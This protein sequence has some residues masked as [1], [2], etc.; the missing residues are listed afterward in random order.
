M[1]DHARSYPIATLEE[2]QSQLTAWRSGS[3]RAKR[4]PDELWDAAVSLC[5]EHSVC[6]VSRALGLDYKALRKRTLR[7]EEAQPPRA[8]VELAPL[9]GAGEVLIECHDTHRGQLRVHC[10]RPLDP[11]VVDL[12]KGFFGRQ[13]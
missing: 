1:A 9:S 3:Q 5:A 8:F 4:I 2:V 13:R 6:K 7:L 12:V 10:K 11:Q